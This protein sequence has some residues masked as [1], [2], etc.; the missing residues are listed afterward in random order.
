MLNP[1]METNTR[2]K[3]R[4]FSNEN[5]VHVYMSSEPNQ[6]VKKRTPKVFEEKIRPFRICQSL[7]YFKHKCE[8]TDVA[9]WSHAIMSLACECANRLFATLF[10]ILQLF[11]LWVNVNKPSKNVEKKRS[12]RIHQT[13]YLRHLCVKCVAQFSPSHFVFFFRWEIDSFWIACCCCFLFFITNVIDISHQAFHAKNYGC[14]SLI[15][16]HFFLFVLLHFS[17]IRSSFRSYP[18]FYRYTFEYDY[19]IGSIIICCWFS[20]EYFGLNFFGYFFSLSLHSFV[21]W[22]VEQFQQLKSW[23]YREREWDQC[24]NRIAKEPKPVW[25]WSVIVVWRLVCSAVVRISVLLH[26]SRLDIS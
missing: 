8:Y 6:K 26:L 16:S 7:H 3:H 11:I 18:Q 24:A 15:V 17:V 22:S 14:S 5:K 1:R 25:F 2:K 13:K 21:Y 19:V 9:R 12:D 20:S 4:I 10:L 23:I